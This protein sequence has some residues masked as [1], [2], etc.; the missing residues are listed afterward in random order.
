LGQK[1]NK[2][3]VLQ[4]E[5]LNVGAVVFQHFLVRLAVVVIV[6]VVVD[7]DVVDFVTVHVDVDVFF[8]FF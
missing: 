2:N 3:E 5:V 4:R 8:V 7:I 1:K 6:V